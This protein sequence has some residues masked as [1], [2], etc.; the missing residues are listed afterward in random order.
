MLVAAAALASG[1]VDT[2]NHWDTIS[3]SAGEAAT[4]NRI[5]HSV[6]PAPHNSRRI[7]GNGPRMASVMADYTAGETATPAPIS[8]QSRGTD[9]P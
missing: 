8:S 1:C 2:T 6:D 3:V 5:V 4:W 9:L 7:P